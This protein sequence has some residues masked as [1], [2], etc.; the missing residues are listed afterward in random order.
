MAGVKGRSGRKPGKR[1][2]IPVKR[3]DGFLNAN[4]RKTKRFNELY[5]RMYAKLQPH[6]KETDDL[7]FNLLIQKIVSW[8]EAQEALAAAGNFDTD[9]KTGRRIQ[10]AEF[11][12]ERDAFAD[13]MQLI[14]LFGLAPKFRAILLDPTKEIKTAQPVVDQFI[15][16]DPGAPV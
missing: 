16:D 2:Y 14:P 5:A 12:V 13:L 1:K 15:S 11:K 7:T 6:L 8:L 10:S 4:P 3:A 9:P